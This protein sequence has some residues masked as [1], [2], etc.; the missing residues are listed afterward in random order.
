LGKYRAK[1]VIIKIFAKNTKYLK[2]LKIK[3]LYNEVPRLSDTCY[4]TCIT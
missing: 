3:E 4:Y 2:I 1:D